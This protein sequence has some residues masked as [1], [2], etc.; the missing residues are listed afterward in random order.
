M[1]VSLSNKLIFS[2]HLEE[3]YGA[4]LP[5]ES[6]IWGPDRVFISLPL[7]SGSRK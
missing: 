5:S 3:V 1:I 6:T 4:L 7:T 2:S